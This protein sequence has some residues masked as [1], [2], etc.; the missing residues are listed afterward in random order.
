M[1]IIVVFIAILNVIELASP[2]SNW[3]Y[4]LLPINKNTSKSNKCPL[5]EDEN[6]YAV[7]VLNDD[8]ESSI[9]THDIVSKSLFCP[10]FSSV[11]RIMQM[12][13]SLQSAIV[14]VIEILDGILDVTT[15][16]LIIHCLVVVVHL[17]YILPLWVTV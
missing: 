6:D 5:Q 16:A 1:L 3:Y 15:T 7:D 12:L 17:G 4:W 13:T 14:P 11:E 8:D 9:A 10:F 2:L